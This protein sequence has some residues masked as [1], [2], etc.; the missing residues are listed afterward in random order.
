MIR[1]E[2]FALK[3]SS[4]LLVIFGQFNKKWKN[5]DKIML[6]HCRSP[7]IQDVLNIIDKEFWPSFLD[8]EY[9]WPATLTLEMWPWVKVVTYPW[10]MY[11]NCVKYYQDPKWKYGVMAQTRILYM[12]SQ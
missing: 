6:K 1:I 4:K 9:V 12:C 11:N 3:V 7:I 2:L 8:F 10:V 5:E